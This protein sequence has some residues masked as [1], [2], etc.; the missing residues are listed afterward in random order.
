MRSCLFGLVSTVTANEQQV[1]SG[2]VCR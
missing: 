2:E 1:A